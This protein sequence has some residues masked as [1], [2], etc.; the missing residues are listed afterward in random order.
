MVT[1]T[2]YRRS[3]DHWLIVQTGISRFAVLDLAARLEGLG[4]VVR[5]EPI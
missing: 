4:V 3:G 5:I 2:L 1:Y